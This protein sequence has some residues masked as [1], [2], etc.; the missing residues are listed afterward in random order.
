M[1]WRP[2]VP[3]AQRRAHA[4]RELARL[5]KKAAPVRVEGRAIAKTFWGQAWCENLER[6][7]Y[8]ANRLPRG[9]TYVR[10]GSVVDLSIEPGAVRARV[11]GSE[12][13]TVEIEIAKLAAPRWRAV[14]KACTGKIGSLV[15]LLRGQLSADV[16]AVLA[17]PGAGL[18]PE[19]GDL[20]MDCSC[21]DWAGMCKHVA[22]TL[23][24]VGARLD[25]RPELFFVLREVDQGEL[26]SAAT[27]APPTRGRS[28]AKQIAEDQ[29]GAIFGIELDEPTPR[30]RRK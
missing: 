5:G 20:S 16:L 13:Y 30:R 8:Y 17:R 3:V 18:F 26:L 14:K 1:E 25:Q 19:P 29:L 10:N 2:Y 4:A 21:P 11:A 24:G 22:A 7:S 23:Y 6:Y 15:G 28:R 12:L 27:V 9:R